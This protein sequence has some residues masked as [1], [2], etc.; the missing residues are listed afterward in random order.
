MKTRIYLSQLVNTI[1]ANGQA[2]HG[3]RALVS[4]S[5]GLWT[6][7]PTFC[8]QCISLNTLRPRQ[9]GRQ[10]ADD[11]FKR[12][13]LNESVRITI[14]ISLEFVPKGRIN[15]IPALVQIMAWRRQGAKPLSEPMMVTLLMSLGPN[16]LMRMRVGGAVT[17]PIVTNK[18]LDFGY[19]NILTQHKYWPTQYQQIPFI[20]GIWPFY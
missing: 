15:N 12:M 16:E 13:F 18:G 5:D 19:C 14:K 4:S 9:N 8:W 2:T 17:L 20:F 11:N 6:S 3:A 7:C 10:C 1:A